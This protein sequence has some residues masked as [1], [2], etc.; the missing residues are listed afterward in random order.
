LVKKGIVLGYKVSSK[1]I[2]IDKAKVEV[3]AKLPEPKC[4]KDIR[5]F[6]RACQII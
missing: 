2:E 5:F 4:I 1:G 3:I 6:S